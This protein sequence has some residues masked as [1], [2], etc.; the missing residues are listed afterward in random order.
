MVYY[1][2]T[3]AAVLGGLAFVPTFVSPLATPDTDPSLIIDMNASICATAET[4]PRGTIGFG[5]S[6]GILH[7]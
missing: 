4:R 2:I 3:R 1:S 6:V 5:F 7:P